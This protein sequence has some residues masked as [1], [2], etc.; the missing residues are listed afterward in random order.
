MKTTITKLEFPSEI[1]S[2]VKQFV[3]AKINIEFIAGKK[4]RFDN[5]NLGLTEP[6]KIIFS[7]QNTF[8]V[9]LLYDDDEKYYLH[10]LSNSIPFNK[11]TK[12]VNDNLR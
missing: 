11:L 5:T 7:N 8:F 1:K 4:I 6:H 10:D 12:L 9:V 3:S 2:K